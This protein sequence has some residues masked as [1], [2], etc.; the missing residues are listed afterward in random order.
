VN[1]SLDEILSVDGVGSVAGTKLY[2]YIRENEQEFEDAKMWFKCYVEDKKSV[3]GGVLTGM[4]ILA[5]GTLEKFKRD[6]IKQSVIDNGGKYASSV[7]GK[8]TFM[9]VGSDAGKS[10]LDK[11]KSLGVKMITEQEYIDMIS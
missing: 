9:I 10:K 2:N 5:T 4:T 6:E 7:S 8:L 11:A 1:A 3:D